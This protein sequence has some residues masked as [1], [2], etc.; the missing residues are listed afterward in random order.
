MSFYLDPN[1]A[2]HAVTSS[3][4]IRKKGGGGGEDTKCVLEYPALFP[5]GADQSDISAR[6]RVR[7]FCAIVGCV[8]CVCVY[9][10]TN[11]AQTHGV[12]NL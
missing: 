10:N 2:S 4:I 7:G 9:G 5:A 1:I 11:P 6:R 3:E 12:C 8:L